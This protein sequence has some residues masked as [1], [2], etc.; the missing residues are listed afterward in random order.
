MQVSQISKL[1]SMTGKSYKFLRNWNFLAIIPLSIIRY[2]LTFKWDYLTSS[3]NRFYW[4]LRE[5]FQPPIPVSNALCQNRNNPPS[6]EDS[7]IYE[8]RMRSFG[9]NGFKINIKTLW[10]NFE[11]FLIGKFPWSWKKFFTT[12]AT[13]NSFSL[14]VF[15]KENPSF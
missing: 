8:R 1:G 2:S 11:V 10:Y 14:F 9:E 4:K 15:W 5:Q 12:H 3:N 6:L 13:N 7:L